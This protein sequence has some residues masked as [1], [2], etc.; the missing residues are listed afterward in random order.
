MRKRRKTITME[1][2]TGVPEYLYHYTSIR[3]VE[4]ILRSKTAWASVLHFLN[5][6]TEWRHAFV[7]AQTQIVRRLEDRRNHHQWDHLLQ[8]L[9]GLLEHQ[10]WDVCVFSLSAMPNQLSQWRAYCPTEGG[11]ALRFRTVHLLGQLRA[12]GF[13]LLRCEYDSKAQ[14]K[15]IDAVLSSALDKLPDT[16][17]LQCDQSRYLE[18][19]HSTKQEVLQHIGKI[20]PTQKHSDFR[21]ESEWRAV[22]KVFG[23]D[24]G[25]D[26]HIRGAMAVPHFNLRLDASPGEFPIDEITVGPGPHQDLAYRGLASIAN[27]ARVRIKVSQTPLRSF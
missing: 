13:E 10:I 8:E 15:R 5:D 26:Y 27:Q 25:N 17:A 22:K 20:A 9:V 19:I 23:D 24:P 4:G 21:E 6:S 14:A 2:L 3:G 11:Y 18:V 16:A 7:L 12:Q 1:E